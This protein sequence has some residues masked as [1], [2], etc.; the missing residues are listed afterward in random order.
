MSINNRFT[1]M[2]DIVANKSQVQQAAK[3]MNKELEQV[4]NDTQD[5]TRRQAQAEIAQLQRLITTVKNNE[6]TGR[7][8]YKTID[9]KGQA[10]VDALEQK[11]RDIDKMSSDELV[12][13]AREVEGLT[14]ELGAKASK[15][16]AGQLRTVGNTLVVLE[17]IDVSTPALER[18]RNKAEAY[19][20]NVTI[21]AR[22]DV[23]RSDLNTAK[24]EVA[25]IQ[26]AANIAMRDSERASQKKRRDAIRD[27]DLADKQVREDLAYQRN[28][29][30]LR[31]EYEIAGE[32]IAPRDLDEQAA[33]IT[34]REQRTGKP[35]W[36]PQQRNVLMQH[37]AATDANYWAYNS[38]ETKIAALKKDRIGTSGA[39]QQ[40]YDRRIQDQMDEM[41]RIRSIDTEAALGAWQRDYRDATEGVYKRSAPVTWPRRL[42]TP[43]I[44]AA[45]NEVRAE[46]GAE[47]ERAERIE[48]QMYQ[49]S[50]EAARKAKAITERAALGRKVHHEYVKAERRPDLAAA[51]EA[52]NEARE[53]AFPGEFDYNLYPEGHSLSP[54]TYGITYDRSA[55]GESSISRRGMQ[56]A[57]E[58]AASAFLSG[59]ENRLRSPTTD[60]APKNLYYNQPSQIKHLTSAYRDP[61]EIFRVAAG[62]KS[63]DEK[64]TGKIAPTKLMKLLG[65]PEDYSGKSGQRSA[66]YTVRAGTELHAI[67]TELEHIFGKAG[68]R[69]DAEGNILLGSVFGKDKRGKPIT[70]NHQLATLLTNIAGRSNMGQ[71]VGYLFDRQGADGEIIPGGLATRDLFPNISR[72][73]I[74]KLT[75]DFSL[76]GDTQ[77]LSLL[78]KLDSVRYMQ[79]TDDFD[80]ENFIGSREEHERSTRVYNAQQQYIQS[81]NE[82]RDRY[83]KQVQKGSRTPLQDRK[84]IATGLTR[85]IAKMPNIDE[86][87]SSTYTQEQARSLY[88]ELASEKVGDKTYNELI[89]STSARQIKAARL[90]KEQLARL[91]DLRG[92]KEYVNS[93]DMSEGSRRVLARDLAQNTASAITKE[94]RA[95]FDTQSRY[96]PTEVEKPKVFSNTP[97]Y[98]RSPVEGIV[99]GITEITQRKE[100]LEKLVQAG[101]ITVAEQESRLEKYVTAKTRTYK[102]SKRDRPS[103]VKIPTNGII[104]FETGD[105]DSTQAGSGVE[106]GRDLMAGNTAP[107]VF[108]E[109]AEVLDELS[110]HRLLEAERV[111]LDTAAGR[112]IAP[113]RIAA[114]LLEE[115]ARGI[116]RDLKDK[117]LTVED[118]KG[119]GI[120]PYKSQQYGQENLALYR[121]IQAKLDK[122]LSDEEFAKGVQKRINEKHNELGTGFDD[123]PSSLLSGR[124]GPATAADIQESIFNEFAGRGREQARKESEFDAE[125]IA[126]IVKAREDRGIKLT[127]EEKRN[128]SLRGVED[129]VEGIQETV[130]ED[131]EAAKKEAKRQEKNRKARERYAAK[132]AAREAAKQVAEHQADPIKDVLNAPEVTAG[133]GI[134]IEPTTSSMKELVE[135]TK[136]LVLHT[137]TVAAE[138]ANDKL[139][140][141]VIDMIEQIT[142]EA[143]KKTPPTKPETQAASTMRNMDLLSARMGRV[144]GDLPVWRSW[145]P[146]LPGNRFNAPVL[147]VA[148]KRMT[149][150]EKQ[151]ARIARQRAK[152]QKE[153][154]EAWDNLPDWDEYD[155]D[156]EQD[157]RDNHEPGELEMLQNMNR[158]MR[159]NPDPGISARDKFRQG[160]RNKYKRM[161]RL[162]Q[163]HVP[164]PGWVSPRNRRDDLYTPI[165]PLVNSNPWIDEDVWKTM[166][167]FQDL[168]K[169]R[170][171]AYNRGSNIF[172]Q[173]S[174]SIGDEL[175]EAMNKR[176]YYGARARGETTSSR[177][178]TRVEAQAA[179]KL[180]ETAAERM[181]GL[182]GISSEDFRKTNSRGISPETAFNAIMGSKLDR[183]VLEDSNILKAAA[184][185]V[186]SIM[187]ATDDAGS[188]IRGAQRDLNARRIKQ[189]E[190]LPDWEGFARD[191]VIREK[192]RSGQDLSSQEQRRYDG[193]TRTTNLR[194]EAEA[195]AGR[196]GLTYSEFTD[197]QRGA[198]IMS[199]AQQATGLSNNKMFGMDP[200][201]LIGIVK[202][203]Q[204]AASALEAFGSESIEFKEA[205]DQARE[206]AKDSIEDD[207]VLGGNVTEGDDRQRRYKRDVS[208]IMNAH[209]YSVNDSFQ[210]QRITQSDI[211]RSRKVQER[212]R[213]LE[214]SEYI[215]DAGQRANHDTNSARRQAR[216]ELADNMAR[217]AERV[218]MVKAGLVNMGAFL[219]GTMLEGAI[220]QA[221]T[222]V[223]D[224]VEAKKMLQRAADVQ[225]SVMGTDSAKPGWW[226]G[227]NSSSPTDASWN[228]V[229]GY[230]NSLGGSR[231]E[232]AN[233]ITKLSEGGENSLSDVEGAMVDLSRVAQNTGAKLKDMVG[234]LEQLDAINLDGLESA[235][236][237][238][239]YAGMKDLNLENFQAAAQMIQQSPTNMLYGQQ[240][241]EQLLVGLA[242]DTKNF[243]GFDSNAYL[244][245]QQA[246]KYIAQ[247]AST[248][249]KTPEFKQDKGPMA[250]LKSLVEVNKL[251]QRLTVLVEQVVE[252][253]GPVVAVF[254]TLVNVVLDVANAGLTAFNS[255][256]MLADVIG[257]IAGL[258]AAVWGLNAALMAVGAGG[259][260]SALGKAMTGLAGSMGYIT[261]GKLAAALGGVMGSF[262][263]I[264]AAM[265]GAQLAGAGFAGT[266]TAG[267]AAARVAVQAFLASLGPIGW[268]IGA[269]GLIGGAAYGAYAKNKSA[270]EKETA[271]RSKAQQENQEAFNTVN[272]V[273]RSNTLGSYSSEG[274]PNGVFNDKEFATDLARGLAGEEGYSFAA[275]GVS[276]QDAEDALQKMADSGDQNLQ[277]LAENV[278]QARVEIDG[279]KLALE[280]AEQ[281]GTRAYTETKFLE[282]KKVGAGEIAS[283]LL[284][285]PTDKFQL[286]EDIEVKA[287]Q[288]QRDEYNANLRDSLKQQRKTEADLPV[289]EQAKI[290]ERRRQLEEQIVGAQ[291]KSAQA[292]GEI[293][294]SQAKLN[295]DKL[296][297]LRATEQSIEA[298]KAQTEESLNQQLALAAIGSEH[299][300]IT[301]LQI[302]ANDLAVKQREVQNQILQ[303][304]VDQAF[305]MQNY[306]DLQQQ[307]TDNATSP[308]VGTGYDLAGVISGD[309]ADLQTG[310]GE[311][312]KYYD[313]ILATVK[314]RPGGMTA[315]DRKLVNGLTQM[316]PEIA[317]ADSADRRWNQE[318][319]TAEKIQRENPVSD[320]EYAKKINEINS[321]GQAAMK[322]ALAAIDAKAKAL[323]IADITVQ[324][325]Q[326]GTNAIKG[327]TE[328]Q[329]FGATEFARQQAGKPE[330]KGTAYYSGQHDGRDYAVPI[331]TRLVA[332]TSG[333]LV[334]SGD[335]GDGFGSRTK[336][337]MDD[338]RTLMYAH[339][340]Q[341]MLARLMAQLGIKP[342]GSK[343]ITAGQLMGVSGDSGNGPAHLHA[344]LYDA[345]GKAIDPKDLLQGVLGGT[346]PAQITGASVLAPLTNPRMMT[347]RGVQ[348]ARNAQEAA[349]QTLLNLQEAQDSLANAQ[350]G[351]NDS[352]SASSDGV[353]AIGTY[354]E[355]IAE[356]N[357]SFARRLASMQTN[358]ARDLAAL[359]RQIAAEKNPDKKS[360]LQNQRAALTANYRSN[361]QDTITSGRETAANLFVDSALN[362][363]NRVDLVDGKVTPDVIR[364]RIAILQKSIKAAQTEVDPRFGLTVQ[365]GEPGAYARLLAELQQQQE[366]LDGK[367]RAKSRTDYDRAVNSLY[368]TTTGYAVGAD[369]QADVLRD[370]I[371]DDDAYSEAEKRALGIGP[372]G[373]I[374]PGS[375]LDKI[376]KISGVQNNIKRTTTNY[377]TQA[378]LQQLSAGKDIYKIDRTGLLSK[379]QANYA[380]A[381]RQF[382]ALR[383]QFPD[384]ASFDHAKAFSLQELQ[385]R[386]VEAQKNLDDWNKS[387][388]GIDRDVRDMR[389][390]LGIGRQQNNR[391]R[392]VQDKI[393]TLLESGRV[394]PNDP[395]VLEMMRLK[396]LANQLDAGDV[397]SSRFKERVDATNSANF[398]TQ[399]NIDRK[400][401]MDTAQ[402]QLDWATSIFDEK[403]AQ[404]FTDPEDRASARANYLKQFQDNV[405]NTESDYYGEIDFLQS[406]NKTVSDM[407]DTLGFT[408]ARGSRTKQVEEMLRNLEKSQRN[409]QGDTEWIELK[410]Q[411][412]AQLARAQEMDAADDALRL[413]RS[414]AAKY[415]VNDAS[416]AYYTNVDA[417]RAYSEQMKEAAKNNKDLQ[418][419]IDNMNLALEKQAQNIK[420]VASKFAT[421]Y[422][423]ALRGIGLTN[424]KLSANLG[425]FDKSIGFRAEQEYTLGKAQGQITDLNAG[426]D[427]ALQQF[428]RQT[429]DANEYM[430]VL[431]EDGKKYAS[432]ITSDEYGVGV[433]KDDKTRTSFLTDVF[434]KNFANQMS[435]LTQGLQDTFQNLA[436][437][438]TDR[439]NTLSPDKTLRDITGGLFNPQDNRSIQRILGDQASDIT[440]TLAF[441]DDLATRSP[442]FKKIWEGEA[443]RAARTAAQT[444]LTSLNALQNDPAAMANIQSVRDTKQQLLDQQTAL[445]NV[446][447]DGTEAEETR[448]KI[449]TEINNLQNRLVELGAVLKKILPEADL[450]ELTNIV[451]DSG[452]LVRLK[453]NALSR[454]QS[455]SNALIRDADQAYKATDRRAFSSTATADYYRTA[456]GQKQAQLEAAGNRQRTLA[457]ER[458]RGAFAPDATSIDDL[459]N[460]K[461]TDPTK[462]KAL[463]DALAGYDKMPQYKDLIGKSTAELYAIPGLSTETI[464]AI[465]SL[466]TEIYNLGEEARDAMANV[467]EGRFDLGRNLRD[468]VQESSSI[469]MER[470]LNAR[471][472]EGAGRNAALA[473]ND[474]ENRLI[475]SINARDN[476]NYG[477]GDL[478]QIYQQYSTDK[479]YGNQIA[480]IFKTTRDLQQQIR[481][482]AMMDSYGDTLDTFARDAERARP[483]IS[484]RSA[485]EFD[486]RMLQQR[487]AYQQS[488]DTSQL[489]TGAQQ[490]VLD[491]IRNTN[492]EI[493]AVVYKMQSRW[494]DFWMDLGRDLTDTLR[495]GFTELI[496]QTMN[497]IWQVESERDKKLRLDMS[498]ADTRKT[499]AES[500]VTQA[501]ADADYAKRMRDSAT[502]VEDRQ[503][504]NQVFTD[505]MARVAQG[506]QDA[507][508]EDSNKAQL[509]NEKDMA[510]AED[511]ISVWATAVE[512]MKNTFIEKISGQMFDEYIG[513]AM[514]SIF[515][516]ISGVQDPQIT[517]T[518]ALTQ[519]NTDFAAQVS[520]LPGA[521]QTAFETVATTQANAAQVMLQAA[522]TMMSAAG[523]IATAGAMGAGSGSNTSGFGVKYNP[524]GGTSDTSF[525]VQYNSDATEAPSTFSVGNGLK[526]NTPQV[527]LTSDTTNNKST[528]TNTQASSK[529]EP[530]IKDS[531][532]ASVGAG[533]VSMAGNALQ[534]PSVGDEMM[535][536][537]IGYLKN[538]VVA[539]AASWVAAGAAGGLA[540]L[541]GAVGAALTNPVTAAVAAVGAGIMLLNNYVD[542]QKRIQDYEKSHQYLNSAT[543][544]YAWGLNDPKRGRQWLQVDGYGVGGSG[545]SAV[546]TVNVTVDE[547]LTSLKSQMAIGSAISKASQLEGMKKGVNL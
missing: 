169:E 92:L 119:F 336:L 248:Q 356:F 74:S 267:L 126:R 251:T 239:Q 405:R 479:L 420:D 371:A 176:D 272:K 320:A 520:T 397:V 146:N 430:K 285:K 57:A 4:S 150:K 227:L 458:M 164:T 440:G 28:R 461:L 361:R 5:T 192:V 276:I 488:I 526:I 37:V 467:A 29:A 84:R 43:E 451:P 457:F 395:R 65:L 331:G 422:A 213:E 496:K 255:L 158:Y 10:T 522:N 197:S 527:S 196:M 68:L 436:L 122:D 133:T 50:R 507:R 111:G 547:P 317:A 334:Y 441:G 225:G 377:D 83:E 362:Q 475:A 490:S 292:H 280:G 509:Q 534:I 139:N 22:V 546:G 414:Q 120:N 262:G 199:L 404:K 47:T 141:A 46:G 58:R 222:Q 412:D 387:M 469:R 109:Y 348:S 462:Q 453:E 99:E 177:Q 230:S 482:A 170:N 411:V 206:A 211:D 105:R 536:Y 515:D 257:I 180:R 107:A 33:R 81:V 162:T 82:M 363:M 492:K 49:R 200:E 173:R 182:L 298:E 137:N 124:G 8:G 530:L 101:R 32:R 229:K 138:V 497:T 69:R 486:L 130:K 290:A 108:S 128:G 416:K 95:L 360:V 523:N 459:R 321:R 215:N 337:V 399:Q 483:R 190:T 31:S 13:T 376:Q 80:D 168:E 6:R 435:T 250:W 9:S 203:I 382:D 93:G 151:Q 72:D 115:N 20:G 364:K 240:Q 163:V 358:Y 194:N 493:E 51:R 402:R 15:E 442:E 236:L 512:G 406:R 332:P 379:A 525:G 242:Q 241:R 501:Q 494:R 277:R 287:L 245:A 284:G 106:T 313:T 328:S 153:N 24:A 132:K 70:K 432:A 148:P 246:E 508:A 473:V 48:D 195:L 543:G 127:E 502:N 249:A 449:Q 85:T 413:S 185:Y 73:Q 315:E 134:S 293:L 400:G 324:T 455:M 372:D 373:K 302:K 265:K 513:R 67:A 389:T 38:A 278:R 86:F 34:E 439:L 40:E 506:R 421:D 305:A 480:D 193:M 538:T 152:T 60:N 532:A 335:N 12:N 485:D 541:G 516:K 311:I 347:A 307:L 487:L 495:T 392:G 275:L 121:S 470:A 464:E 77:G 517:A 322:A 219:G 98:L 243:K 349:Q 210:G 30:L 254:L 426:R 207:K 409:R 282:T 545:K 186:Q 156:F 113:D 365:K 102:S 258:A 129:I 14:K 333:T 445:S 418:E 19:L 149:K 208:R 359:D 235:K 386:V 212:I 291:A 368:N 179:A 542:N 296:M 505:A 408:T 342:G 540:G 234:V 204:D 226:P 54:K 419:Q 283:A 366:L 301:D 217:S 310:N 273:Y 415:E 350:D 66:D 118:L 357:A 88:N 500:D 471:D 112:D 154:Q 351:L 260:A 181:S 460:L 202:P 143:T 178:F 303:T 64:L 183:S 116:Y 544:A 131:T 189:Q 125:T 42:R 247:G 297:E 191:D 385:K 381:S 90:T 344:G 539:G 53:S 288:S 140:E 61:T 339:Q 524:N 27:R 444:R 172:A 274:I 533:L 89:H 264:A 269:I 25:E 346:A 325:A 198:S 286:P 343:R 11:L 370:K 427:L 233:L 167:T 145:N 216:A 518:Q 2:A 104:E 417:A 75:Q 391:A 237:L 403:I 424:T 443:A 472:Y 103:N 510:D 175:S 135:G 117:K 438:L 160:V 166:S 45:V 428:L 55:P 394:A 519:A 504:W 323:G 214:G 429:F 378:L 59:D 165:D 187:N 431:G 537:G 259:T 383:S 528:T 463:T 7:G 114:Q 147:N 300:N 161:P 136:Q 270:R 367:K 56:T 326:Q 62:L 452:Y 157:F 380:T 256:G 35:R 375:K 309:A 352:I 205:M 26:R 474:M 477:R 434:N 448:A 91:N 159:D 289:Q 396:E 39:I 312:K 450:T 252:A 466:N 263:G 218:G 97:A 476:T 531:T 44:N 355:K 304:I 253:V 18:A 184:H 188:I 425:T 110:N 306:L 228:L 433:I 123:R 96:L 345:N 23:D 410:K 3:E 142:P 294:I 484:E 503:Y 390:G 369:N 511:Q 171:I 318:L 329:G 201:A 468:S 491:D 232:A 231:V 316:A 220:S 314:A 529:P 1:I 268:I 78:R 338:G 174:A 327:F 330:W 100:R 454:Q 398:M 244:A 52:Y 308:D 401:L 407:S 437:T 266:L 71:A 514:Q 79:R 299:A 499:F 16:I 388:R 456:I 238:G 354:G 209:M 446:V 478:S 374:I 447:G 144:E 498:N 221:A 279:Y 489:D 535:D 261:S 271:E 465:Q 76:T 94:E 223:T 36:N 481:S 281:A 384:Q 353:G 21:K 341:Q 340:D 63:T 224:I 295:E 17:R 521:V 393:D 41:A 319:Q 87:L 155:T 423:S